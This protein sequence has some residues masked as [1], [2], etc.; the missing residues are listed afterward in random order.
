MT[1]K[2]SQ[3][4]RINDKPQRRSFS[5]EYKLKILQ[6]IEGL[7][8]KEGRGAV[9][10]VLRREGLYASQVISWRNSLE[11]VIA[12]GIPAKRRGRKKDPEAAFLKE[13]ARLE[14]QIARLK[15]DNRQYR[16]IIEAQKKIAEIYPDEVGP[17]RSEEGD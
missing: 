7:K 4:G 5:P 8:E 1:E 14:K 16:L 13:K 15:E 2:G 17:K 12:N 10:K 3:S 6:E 11:E 9:G